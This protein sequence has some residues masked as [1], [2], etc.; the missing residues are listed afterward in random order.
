MTTESLSDGWEGALRSFLIHLQA[1]RAPKTAR[2]YRTQVSGLASW[3]TARGIGLHQFADR[4]LDEYLVER[5]ELGRRETTRHH[6]ELAAKVFCKWSRKNGFMKRDPLKERKLRNPAQP[7]KH[8][9]TEAEI[10]SLLRELPR[11]YDVSHN[12]PIQY[13]PAERRAFHR[14]RTTAVIMILL[15][16]A[17][18]IGEALHLRVEDFRSGEREI[19]ITQSK[20]RKP[21]VIP[22][23]QKTAAAVAEWLRVRR[24]VLR[25]VPPDMD[26]GW[27]FISETGG[28]VDEG[29]FNKSLHRVSSFAG[30]AGITPHTLRHFTLNRY[31]LVDLAAAQRIAGHADPKT[32]MIYTQITSDRMRDLAEKVDIMGKVTGMSAPKA[33]KRLV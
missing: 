3:A 10:R 28:R 30:V 5:A 18:R 11:Y 9:P 17:C 32:T 22:V 14:E 33:R 26:E 13:H 20:G 24:R 7:H 12:P 16:T 23:C 2:F 21:R 27:L 8:V 19:A 25:D 31:S 29:K 1:V 4:H 6:D 15:D